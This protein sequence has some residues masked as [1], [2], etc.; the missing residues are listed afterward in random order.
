MVQFQPGANLYTQG[1][2]SRPESVE[3]P[4]IDVR[5]PAAT[6]KQYPIG[7]KWVDKVANKT[8]TLTSFSSALGVVSANWAAEG[9]S[10]D[11]FSVLGTA[12]QI[13]STVNA[14]VATLSIPSA[15]QAPGSVTAATGLTA[16]TGGVT[17]SAG[18]IAATL[19][20]VSAG[21]TVTAGTDL[22]STA[23]NVLIN[24]SA[25][26][27]RVKGGA[28][29]DFIGDSVLVAGT[30]TIANTNI[31][32]GDQVYVTRYDINGSTALGVFEATISAGVSFTINSRKPADASVEA[33][34]VS[35][36]KYFIVR[37]I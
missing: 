26:Q 25:K 32:A 7:K 35:K 15:F 29:T 22:A 19:G 27:L 23:G 31:A 16:T 11:I 17:A 33:N 1:F 4:H 28:V 8:Y 9:S 6:D 18:N 20:S 10:A 13:T 30:V 2:G 34:D 3:V 24:G 5:A 21:T 12:N 36:V 14:G 37:A